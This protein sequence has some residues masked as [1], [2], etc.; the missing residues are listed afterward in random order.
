MKGLRKISLPAMIAAMVIALLAAWRL[1]DVL[2]L[3]AA[4]LGR[5]AAYAVTFALAGLAC[6]YAFH[7]SDRRLK[8][9]SYMLGF[10][11][12][13]FIVIGYPMNTLRA[14]PETLSG[15]LGLAGSIAVFTVVLGSAAFA[16]YRGALWLTRPKAPPMLADGREKRE[17]LLS[18]L[19]GNGFFAFAVIL[20]AAANLFISG[21]ITSADL[22]QFF[23]DYESITESLTSGPLYLQILAVAIV[24]PV[25]E[26]F[27][28]RGLVLNRL[29]RLMPTF[30]AVL[31]QGM[32]FGVIHM[33]ILQGSYAAL[34][35]FLLG[36]LY[37]RY[38]SLLPCF[39]LH[40]TLNAISVLVPSDFGADWSPILTIVLS[41]LVLALTVAAMEIIR[42]RGKKKGIA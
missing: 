5:W 32:L 27:L 18:R 12:A 38:E 1:S 24:A 23:P 7:T 37:V 41:F 22:T 36:Y 10:V 26:E 34:I 14:L 4:N 3:P 16:L 25:L 35:G 28:M 17:S 9:I 2:A 42:W 15:G 29:R 33:N 11:L 30:A 8:S 6:A 20:A 13:C 19:T 21:I 39:A 31:L 40:I